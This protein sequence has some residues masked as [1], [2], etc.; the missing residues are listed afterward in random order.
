MIRD[1]SSFFN[2]IDQSLDYIISLLSIGLE[3]YLQQYLDVLQY[4]SLGLLGLAGIS[5]MIQKKKVFGIQQDYSPIFFWSLALV[6][7]VFIKN[8]NKDQTAYWFYI[9]GFSNGLYV[10]MTPRRFINQVAELV[11]AFV[12]FGFLIGVLIYYFSEQLVQ[13]ILLIVLMLFIQYQNYRQN[14]KLLELNKDELFLQS[15]AHLNGS[16]NKFSCKIQENSK[17]VIQIQE[18]GSLSRQEASM[19]LIQNQVDLQAPTQNVIWQNFIE[20][21]EDYISKFYFNVDDLENNINQAQNNYSMQKFLQDNKSQL[22]NLFK[23]MKVS[24]DL[25]VKLYE[26]NYLDKKQDSLFDWIKANATS[27]NFQ[28]VNQQRRFEENLVVSSPICQ[29]SIVM[30]DAFIEKSISGLSAIQLIQGSLEVSNLRNRRIAYGQYNGKK[31][32]YNFYIQISFF[33][34]EVDGVQHQVIAVLIRD[35]EKQVKQIKS[36]LK[37]IQKINSTIKFLQQQAD[38]IQRLHRKIVLQ[39]NAINEIQRSNQN[40]QLIKRTNSICS[41]KDSVDDALSDFSEKGQKKFQITQFINQLQF[42]FLRIIQ[43]HFNYFEVFSVN[44]IIEFEKKRVDITQTIS[45]LINQFQYDEIVITKKIRFS[46]QGDLQNKY[47]TSDL[48][49]LKQ[50]LF[51]II[52]NSI[53]SYEFDQINQKTQRLVQI[54]LNNYEQNIRFE[55]IDYGCGLNEENINPRRLDDCKL[56]LAA[57][58]KLI[59]LLGGYNKQITISR[60]QSQHQTKVQ[61]ELPNDLYVDKADIMGEDF[62]FDTIQLIFTT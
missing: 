13:S 25:N 51:N 61:F 36:N 47:I 59:K 10:S 38:V 26:S 29:Q 12:Q 11:K 9:L 40:T 52:Y 55:V 8:V 49:R 34:E 60:S 3:V 39:Q 7:I 21:S 16:L 50:L 20:Q 48:R 1:A 5:K 18:V 56:G 14:V 2:R 17:S 15:N 53:K 23:D 43:N 28:D 42:Q 27:S 62:D 54:N 32:N 19:H 35:L 58:Q 37:N 45:L 33:L 6:R 57:S 31:Y 4:F 24:S 46:I 30:L 44:D 41:Y 22:I